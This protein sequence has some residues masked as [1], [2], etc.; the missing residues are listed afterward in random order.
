MHYGSPDKDPALRLARDRG[1]RPGEDPVH[2]RHPGRHRRDAARPRRVARRPPRRARAPRPRAGG[3]RAELPREAAHGDAD[4]PDA[5]LRE[6]AAAVAVARLVLGPRMRIQVPPNLSDPAEFELLRARRRRRL[7]RRLAADRRPRQ[8]R[9]A[10]AAPR[11][12]RA[13]HRGARLRPARAPHRAP[14]VRARTPRSGSTR[15]SH[16]RPGAGGRRRR[17]WRST[18]AASHDAGRTRTQARSGCRSPPEQADLGPGDAVRVRSRRPGSGGS[19]GARHPTRCALDDADWVGAARPTGADLDALTATAD[20]VRRY[21]VGEAVSL[22]VNRNSLDASGRRRGGEPDTYGLDDA[23]RDRR[24]RLGLGATELCVQGLLAGIRGPARLP[25]HR[26]DDQGGDARH[27]PARLPAR[28][29][30]CDLADRGGLVSTARSPRCARRAS[31]RCRARASR[32][33]ANASAPS[34]RPATSR[35]TGGSRAITAAH[36]AGFRSTSVLFYGHV[37]TAAERVAHLR[38]LRAIQAETGGFTEFV[39]IPLPGSAACRSWPGAAPIDEHR[40]MFAVARLMLAAAIPH[41]QVAWTRVGASAAAVLLARA[42]D[43]L[44]GIAARRAR[45]ARGR[46]EHGLELPVADAARIAARLFRPFRQR[47]TD[48]RE[49]PRRLATGGEPQTPRTADRVDVAIVGAG[50]AGIGMALALRRAGRES[51][52]VLERADVRRRH[53]ARQHLSRRRVRRS[54][55]PVRLRRAP[56][57]ALVGRLRTGRRDPDATSSASPS[58]SARRIRLRLRTAAAPTGTP[59]AVWQLETAAAHPAIEA[60][61]ARARVRTTDRALGARTSPGLETFP[62]PAVP[63]ARWDH[64]ADLAGARVAV[65]GTG[66]SAVQLLPEVAR[67]AARV[68]LFQ[69]TPGLDRAPGRHDYTEDE[70]RRFAVRSRRRWRACARSST[71]R[72][73]RASRRDPETP[74]PPQRPARSALAHLHAQIADPPLRVRAH[75]RLR[76]RLQTRAALRRLLP[77]R[78]VRRA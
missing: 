29:T 27:A 23:R 1:C 38:A 75:P 54:F 2:H 37:E 50:F 16:P 34:S 10:V 47:T 14:P 67:M 72:A 66:A 30:S 55:A 17:A 24:G 4:A 36:R 63:L 62:G 53:L 56:E 64:G 49:V 52:V 74:R 71:P 78:R 43:D 77:G 76:V 31:T 25:R 20:D 28:R 48:Y 15:R 21:T 18:D 69:R 61:V 13:A 60:R 8:P 57:P 73:R 46:R 58:A 51:F 39:P 40:A 9:A 33:S 42:A 3:D 26:P 6:Y 41:V 68:T 11:R 12:P 19:P 70:R 65:V 59:R 5:S 32:C 45:A 35:S 7:G 44:G 22:V